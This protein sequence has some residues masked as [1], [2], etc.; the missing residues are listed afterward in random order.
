MK[1]FNTRNEATIWYDNVL[2]QAARIVSDGVYTFKNGEYV[3]SCKGRE[4]FERERRRY[5]FHHAVCSMIVRELYKPDD[6]QQLLLEWPHKSETDPNRIAYTRDERAGEQDRQVITTMGKYLT[7]HFPHAPDHVIRD[8]VAQYTYE[9]GIEITNDIE[10]MIHAVMNGPRS[11]MSSA[12][13]I[14]CSDGIRRHPYAVYQPA[15]GWSMAIRLDTDK[16]VLGRCLLWTD[17]NDGENKMFVRSYKRERDCTSHSGTDEAIE[18]HLRAN[19]FK[20][21]EDWAEGARLELF[22][23]DGGGYL[24]PYIDG[25]T[26]NVRI[27][28]R[29]EMFIDADGDIESSS[30]SGMADVCNCNCDDCGA[31]FNDDDEGGWTGVYEDNHVCQSCLDNEYTYAYSRRGNQYYIEND[32]VTYVNGDYYDI[33]YLD[34]NNIVEL[35]DGE[36]E[37]LDNAVYVESEDAYYRCDDDDVCYAEDTNQHELREN[38]WQCN[39]SGNWYTDG[40]KCV[41][42]DGDKYHPDNAPEVEE[43]DDKT[44]TESTNL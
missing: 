5:T 22:E 26:Q 29:N 23:V 15:Y 10:K 38:C 7:R 44:E 17:P 4:W 12:F 8:I 30:T 13:N 40:E 24:M 42:I 2:M 28:N 27:N 35:H 14:R 3:Y 21:W 31:R 36:Y 16:T 20:K 37:D 6:W 32:R 19:G 39:E 1:K 43:S 41:E 11:C 25:G 18:S 33:E 9:G 34:D